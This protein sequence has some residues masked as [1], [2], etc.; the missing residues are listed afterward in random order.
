MQAASPAFETARLF[1]IAGAGVEVLR[2]FALVLVIAAG[3]SVFIAL[4]GALE[5]RRNDLAI[6]RTLGASP[7]HLLRLMVLEGLLL[8]LAGAMLGLALGHALTALLGAWLSAEHGLTLSAF[9]WQAE[10]LALLALALVV[11][12][13]AA[14]L[15]A[16]GAYRTDIARTLSDA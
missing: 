9:I 6:L 5:E 14:L 8:A 11:G 13:V 7:G 1:R 2:G 16:W 3:L 4:Y 12:V 15:P 10:E